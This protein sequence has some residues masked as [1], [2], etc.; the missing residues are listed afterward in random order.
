MHHQMNPAQ[1]ADV[2]DH[3]DDVSAVVAHLCGLVIVSPTIDAIA[4]AIGRELGWSP[5]RTLA[6]LDGAATAGLVERWDRP[7]KPPT[8]TLTPLAASKAGLKL[9]RNIDR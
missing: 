8:A 5:L 1:S 3:P 7:G 2:P 9:K 4:D 6:A